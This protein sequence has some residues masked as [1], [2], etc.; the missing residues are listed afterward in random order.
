MHGES[1]GVTDGKGSK[2][3]AGDPKGHARKAYEGI[4]RMLFHNEIVAGQKI[5]YRDLAERLGMSQTPV[6]QALKWLEF[7]Q[8]VHHVPNRGYYTAPI[9]L[10]EVGEIYELR[11]LIEL[12]L[13]PKTMA[14]LDNGKIRRLEASFNAHA[15]ASREVYLYDR[16][17]RDMQFHLTLASL[18]GAGVQQ[19][20]LEDLF[21]LL[22][23][24]Y[25]GKFLFSTPMASADA[26]HRALIER[27]AARDLSGA[28]KTLARHI[29]R[30]RDHVIQGVEKL[31]AA[32][33]L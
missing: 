12:S 1:S 22:Y 5:A 6:I 19:K 23:L 14:A 18:S 25:G 32:T 10:Q 8:L 28:R 7:Q 11:E 27:I 26:D 4:R 29:R 13:L 16:L 31:L 15:R 17:E 24:K 20:V 30:V 2:K 33:R 21:D 3:T 9:R